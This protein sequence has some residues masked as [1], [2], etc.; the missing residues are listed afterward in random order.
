MQEHPD[1]L[2]TICYEA[3]LD[4]QD[5]LTGGSQLTVGVTVS[6]NG[7]YALYVNNVIDRVHLDRLSVPHLSPS[8]TWDRLQPLCD[9]PKDKQV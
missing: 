2:S 5:R 3:K 9:P 1:N 7:L 6:L 8:V 4:I